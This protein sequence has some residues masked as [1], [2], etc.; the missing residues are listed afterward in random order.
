MRFHY[1]NS[2]TPKISTYIR[3]CKS[4]KV[5]VAAKENLNAIFN[6]E[7]SKFELIE[8]EYQIG[9]LQTYRMIKASLLKISPKVM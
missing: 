4:N 7:I 1:V 3:P 9:R 6:V 2:N 5:Y 8:I